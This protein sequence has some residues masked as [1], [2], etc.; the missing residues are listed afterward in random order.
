MKMLNQVIATEK[1]LHEGMVTERFLE[2]QSEG[3]FTDLFTTFS[4]QLV[5][6]FRARGCEFAEDLAQDVMLA[7]YRKA[8]QLRDRTLFRA[9]LFKIARHALVR[10]Y[11][12]RAR[13]VDTVDL[14][15]VAESLANSTNPP[16]GSPAFEFHNWVSVLDTREQETLKLRF[17]D[18]LEYH[19]IASVQATPIGTV[20]WRVHSAKRKLA[21]YLRTRMESAALSNA[22]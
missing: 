4:P 11:E 15:E 14:A 19:E 5:A 6:Y 17:V 12:K 3:S 1:M 16:G 18:E 7:V 22:A 21:P 13:E 8:G 9:W 2:T 10:H 20:Q